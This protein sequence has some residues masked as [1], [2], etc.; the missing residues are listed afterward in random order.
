MSDRDDQ[1]L[2]PIAEWHED[3]G[4]VLWWLCPID[5]P[6]YVGSPITSDWP[7]LEKHHP[8]LFFSMLPAVWEWP[9]Y[10]THRDNGHFKDDR[11]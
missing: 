8:Q 1:K 7:F 3:D 4:A 2:Y 5:S 9:D 6:P 11:I 10:K